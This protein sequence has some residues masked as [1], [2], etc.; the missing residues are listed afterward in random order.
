MQRVDVPIAHVMSVDVNRSVADVVQ[1]RD[2]PRQ[3]GLARAVRPDE[4]NHLTRFNR[5]RDLIN[6][7]ENGSGIKIRGVAKLN[8]SEQLRTKLETFT[9]SGP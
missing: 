5:Q 6:G 8:A 7:R 4:R 9:L 1:P 3:C 2:E